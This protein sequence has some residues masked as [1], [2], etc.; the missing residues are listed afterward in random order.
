MNHG[1]GLVLRMHALP[2]LIGGHLIMLPCGPC[3]IHC[4]LTYMQK[5]LVACAHLPGPGARH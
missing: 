3:A 2:Q 1:R 4:P 5:W